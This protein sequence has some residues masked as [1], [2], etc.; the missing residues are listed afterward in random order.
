MCVGGMWCSLT[1]SAVPL[2]LTEP[3]HTRVNGELEGEDGD[4]P[5]ARSVGTVA[6]HLD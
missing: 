3:C 1:C 2:H 4:V 6:D 5:R